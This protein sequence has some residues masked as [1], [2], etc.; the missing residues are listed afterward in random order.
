MTKEERVFL[1]PIVREIN[2]SYKHPDYGRL[3]LQGCRLDENDLSVI[4]TKM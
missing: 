2:Y 4:I 1:G 3:R